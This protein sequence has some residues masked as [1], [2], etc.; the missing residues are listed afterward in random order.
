[1]STKIP[2]RGSDESNVYAPRPPG[3][4]VMDYDKETGPLNKESTEEGKSPEEALAQVSKVDESAVDVLD[5]LKG[6]Q[7]AR[8]FTV[9]LMRRAGMQVF[10]TDAG[11]KSE[12]SFQI[13]KETIHGPADLLRINA[14]LASGAYKTL[15]NNS[16]ELQLLLF[17]ASETGLFKAQS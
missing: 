8:P 1:V 6:A 17:I 15:N 3:S 2:S 11:S 4:K 16:V 7:F 5:L 9:T 14:A 13:H 12:A 10:K